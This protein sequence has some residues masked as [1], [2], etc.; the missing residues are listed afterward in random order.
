[1]LHAKQN[2]LFFQCFAQSG[3]NRSF[4]IARILGKFC[5]GFS[6][7]SDAKVAT[8]GLII[9]KMVPNY[10]ISVQNRVPLTAMKRALVNEKMAITFHP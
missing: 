8:T 3:H 5:T 7:F 6:A 2:T 9:R 1:M 10:P 4:E